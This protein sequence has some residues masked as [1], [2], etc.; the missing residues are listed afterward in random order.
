[1]WGNA[2]KYNSKVE[3]FIS[4]PILSLA[5]LSVKATPPADLALVAADFTAKDVYSLQA[6]GLRRGNF[7]IND[8]PRLLGVGVW[9]NMADGLV[10]INGGSANGLVLRL[11]WQSYNGAGVQQQANIFTPSIDV[12]VSEFNEIY[13]MDTLFDA[14][15]L[16]ANIQS[17]TAAFTRIRVS[18]LAT[19]SNFSTI[20]IDPA[21]AA[22]AFMIQ[23]VLYIEHSRAMK[24]A[25][26]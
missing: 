12:K 4:D 5:T 24:T 10:Q 9:C 16:Q 18:W 3:T 17:D 11:Q 20:S 2:N 1:M 26:F 6:A 7:E 21:Y 15:G 25:G 23:P 19:A 14:S 22:K 8:I 13:P